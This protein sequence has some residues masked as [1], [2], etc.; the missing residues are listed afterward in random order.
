MLGAPE[1]DLLGPGVF[2]IQGDKDLLRAFLTSYGYSSEML[3]KNLSSKL[4]ALLLLHKY[5]NLN[6]QVRI[7]NWQEKVQ[8]LEELEHLLWE[9]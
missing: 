2:L 9:M 8:N 3:S 5:S 1:Y 4:N 6:I 7:P